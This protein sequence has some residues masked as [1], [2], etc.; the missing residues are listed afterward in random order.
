V[1]AVQVTRPAVGAG[2]AVVVGVSIHHAVADGHSVWQFMSAWSAVS[3]SP[4]AASGLAPPT[5]D[6]TAIRYPKADEVA[7]KFVRTIAPRTS[8]RRGSERFSSSGPV[9]GT[10]TAT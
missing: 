10:K 5:F 6:R 9:G 4:E 2:R 1:L 7:R 8:S 3:R